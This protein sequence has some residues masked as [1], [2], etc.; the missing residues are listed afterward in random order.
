LQALLAALA[1]ALLNTFDSTL[2]MSWRLFVERL[3]LM[4]E[5]RLATAA[6]NVFRPII[7]GV[8]RVLRTPAAPW[9]AVLVVAGLLLRARLITR[10]PAQQRS[11]ALAQPPR[12]TPQPPVQFAAT[13]PGAGGSWQWRF[14]PEPEDDFHGF[15]RGTVELP[16]PA[17]YSPPTAAAP[18]LLGLSTDGATHYG[19]ARL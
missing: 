1:Q 7:L 16:F 15:R 2:H 11:H 13:V 14:V 4:L 3:S 12:H 5:A 18:L 6:E 10:H 19:R 9:W 8:A 17:C